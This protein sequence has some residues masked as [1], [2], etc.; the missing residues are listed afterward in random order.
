MP[1]AA[2][3][4]EPGWR[5][6]PTRRH[7]Y[8]WW[9]GVDWSDQV[10]DRGV[11]TVDLGPLPRVA[12]LDLQSVQRR[13]RHLAT[14]AVGVAALLGV[15]G[16]VWNATRSGP[17]D[18]LGVHVVDPDP[19]TSLAEQV[20]RLRAG[21]VVRIRA[22]PSTRVDLALHVATD[23]STARAAAVVLAQGSGD[24]PDERAR[25]LFR[26]GDE[27]VADAEA[28]RALATT[29]VLTTIDPGGTGRPDAGSFT[30]RADG[31]YRLLVEVRARRALGSVRLVV[32][33][34]DTRFDDAATDDF[35]EDLFFSEPA[36]Y[37]N[38]ASYDAD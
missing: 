31:D 3:D 18:G 19:T 12:G 37:R 38:A 30:A 14:V 27:V 29:V 6:D 21:D 33:R 8:R 7:D 13:R 34:F 17:P 11:V 1:P 22:E 9:T 4:T 35:Y 15:T 28:R 20:V 32:E 23:E 16:V 26:F 25:R 2:Q 24:D 5:A 10:G 36:F